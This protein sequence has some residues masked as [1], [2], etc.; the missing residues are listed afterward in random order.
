M[1]QAT[2]RP[3]TTMLCT[4]TKFQ[5]EHLLP[6][7]LCWLQA[8]YSPQSIFF[9]FDGQCIHLSCQL[10]NCASCKQHTRAISAPPPPR[11]YI[12]KPAP[13]TGTIQERALLK[14]RSITSTLG[15]D[16]TGSEQ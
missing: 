6:R 1:D 14:R 7:A 10:A 8:G 16:V 2:L 15:F 5:G 4:A 13:G 12:S 9:G 11:P 3:S